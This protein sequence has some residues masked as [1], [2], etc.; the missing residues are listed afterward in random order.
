MRSDLPVRNMWAGTVAWHASARMQK[1]GPVTSGAMV[2][3]GSLYS[4]HHASRFTF[5]VLRMKLPTPKA[6]LPWLGAL[7]VL[8]VALWVRLPSPVLSGDQSQAREGLPQSRAEVMRTGEPFRPAHRDYRT[9]VRAHDMG[10]L[11]RRISDAMNAA[12]ENPGD[13]VA[14]RRLAGV[15]SEA[16]PYTHALYE[17]GRRGEEYLAALIKYDDLLTT[18]T[19][20]LGLGVEQVRTDTFPV[21]ETL[22]R[23]PLPVGEYTD[24]YPP[25]IPS[26]TVLTQTV[27]LQE[28][29]AALYNSGASTPEQR[30]T[31]I[32]NLEGVTS[33]L[34][35]SGRS[36]EYVS[37]IHEEFRDALEDYEAAVQR[38]VEERA[39]PSPLRSIGL[40]VNLAVALVVLAG[41]GLLLM[42]RDGIKWPRRLR[43]SAT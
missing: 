39:R 23:Y 6:L 19:R 5:H 4:K 13:F 16:I 37:A 24:P 15:A 28:T 7:A 10:T 32:S 26:S 8:A 31:M 14:V 9:F 42:G 29:I 25:I 34:W 40:F 41:V 12:K 30:L 38:I 20:G 1:H 35:E 17:Y 22:K 11:L 27:R 36:I 18:W 43:T 2:K 33:Q 3:L 21:I